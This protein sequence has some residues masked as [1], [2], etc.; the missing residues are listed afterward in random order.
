MPGGS[1]QLAEPCGFGAAKI[2]AERLKIQA[3]I[4]R[5]YCEREV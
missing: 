5:Q 4:S 1:W 3:L 2:V